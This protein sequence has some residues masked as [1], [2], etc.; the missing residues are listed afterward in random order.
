[1]YDY[2]DLD[3]G[4]KRLTKYTTVSRGVESIFNEKILNK[5]LILKLMNQY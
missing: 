2:L 3:Y 1:M 5:K 4:I